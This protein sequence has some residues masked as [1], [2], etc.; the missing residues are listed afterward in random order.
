MDVTFWK[1]HI[2]GD[3]KQTSVCPELRLGRGVSHKGIRKNC[4]VMGTLLGL[5]GS[6]VSTAG[7]C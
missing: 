6:G 4:G 7:Y 1:R 3:R 2:Y 5:N